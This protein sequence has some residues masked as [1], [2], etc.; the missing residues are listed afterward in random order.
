MKTTGKMK[1]PESIKRI[2]TRNL[3]LVTSILTVI[4][5]MVM[6][7]VQVFYAQKNAYDDAADRFVQIRHLLDDNRSDRFAVQEDLEK[8]YLRNAHIA[9]FMIENHPE[10]QGDAEKLR[11]IAEVLQLDEICIFDKTGLLYGGTHP[12]YYGMTF[13]SGEQMSF[14]K[15]MLEDKTLELCQDMT[16]N[17]YDGRKMQYAAVWSDSG[18]FI[19]EVGKNAEDSALLMEKYDLSYIFSLI[20]V[21]S[22]AEFYAADSETGEIMGSTVTED[23]GKN[24]ADIGLKLSRIQQEKK[25]FHAEVNGEKCHCVF[26]ADGK[27]LLGRIVPNRVIYSAVVP[28]TLEFAIVLL[29]V[30]MGLIYAIIKYMDR[31]IIRSIQKINGKLL[32]IT[33]GYLDERIE[34]ED[35]LEF[36]QLSQ[37][38]NEMVESLADKVQQ[39]ERFFNIVAQHSNRTLYSFDL[40]SG[41]TKLWSENS[42]EKDILAHIYSGEY[43]HEAL[44][45]NEYILKESRNDVKTFFNDIYNGTPSGEMNVHIALEDGEKK[46]FSFMYSVIFDGD[47]PVTAL[48]S[49][50]DI[51]EDHERE[52]AHRRFIESNVAEVEQSISYME[53]DL[54]ADVIEKHTGQELW[55]KSLAEGKSY[56]EYTGTYS[57]GVD[58]ETNIQLRSMYCIESLLSAYEEGRRNIEHVWKMQRAEDT[59]WVQAKTELAEDPY[60]GHIKAYVI[61]TD[62]TQQQEEQQK[63][64]LRA[65][66]DTMTGLLRK[67]VGEQRIQEYLAGDHREN[68]IMIILDMD[69]LKGINDELGHRMGDEA[70]SGIARVM[71]EYFNSDDILV[72]AGGD[73]FVALIKNRQHM[74]NMGDFMTGLLKKLATISVGEHNEKTVHCSAGCAAISAGDRSYDDVFKRADVALYHVKRNGK[75]NYAFYT[76]EMEQANYEFRSKKLLSMK[77]IDKFGMVEMQNL[78]DTIIKFY[79]LVLSVNVSANTYHI[80]EEIKEG[81]FAA[82][83]DFGVLDDFVVMSGS[84]VHPEDRDMFYNK[85]SRKALIE[86]YERGEDKVQHT[87]R[88]QTKEQMRKVECMVNFYVDENGDICDFTILRW[89]D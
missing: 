61:M 82:V 80:M 67:E 9:A 81:V 49:I 33:E 53:A 32:Y 17:T 60:S 70:I 39:R 89:A 24:L 62:V 44:E 2:I 68:G 48:I 20:R 59:I 34:L 8:K 13:D 18:E 22:E 40:D 36:S 79:Q 43:T 3:L 26:Q 7:A 50:E 64:K 27:V 87:F 54:T 77:N 29:L 21:T 63:M 76:P 85:L 47:R 52:I 66:Y 16:E 51:T 71:R 65:D 4:I 88:F 31:I 38:I 19:V 41:R 56:S 74:E 30:V 37:Y 15:P 73:E 86:A 72:R 25:G 45:E 12:E 57:I 84:A 28:R 14:F 5:V 58:E 23:I 75:N 55:S 1:E 6:I 10:L 78:L 83:P 69:D 11:G 35:N 46:W 42:G